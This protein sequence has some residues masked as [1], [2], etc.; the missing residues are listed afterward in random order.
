[1]S[2]HLHALL[3]RELAGLRLRA[4]RP[5]LHIVETGTIRSSA[6]TY[7]ANDGWSTLF[8]ARHVAEFGGHF[9]S[10]DL[11]TEAAD[12]VLTG[13]GVAAHANLMCGHSVD[14]LAALHA[15]GQRFDVAYLDSDNDP[16]LILNEF[17]I[18]REMVRCPGL[19]MVDD[20]DPGSATVRKGHALVPWLDN[21]GTP[22]RIAARGG[23]RHHTGVLILDV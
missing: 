5:A 18:V 10:V 17:T 21:A 14:V 12:T 20:V 9:V 1:M 16:Q 19:I 4:G 2:E 3:E 15:A 6:S 11:D 7:A 22:Y 23:D 8:F 13:Y